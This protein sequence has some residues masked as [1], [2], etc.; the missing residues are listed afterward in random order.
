M[1]IYKSVHH[2]VHTHTYIYIYLYTDSKYTA[3]EWEEHDWM[4]TL[5]TLVLQVFEASIPMVGICF[6]HQFLAC[7]LGG[8]SGVSN[9]GWDC[10]YTQME[11]IKD[12]WAAFLADVGC[13]DLQTA[14]DFFLPEY[15]RDAVLTL[16]TGAD[17]L[18]SSQLCENEMY[19]IGKKVMCIQGHPELTHALIAEYVRRDA[20]DA[21]S[22]IPK[23]I[24]D[25]AAR[26]L[27]LKEAD[28]ATVQPPFRRMVRG[29]LGL[30]PLTAPSETKSN[31]PTAKKSGCSIL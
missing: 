8:A 12:N 19:R 9:R 29:F 22:P 4:K 21:N 18:L 28:D 31:P 6:G 17:L 30:P 16:P 27:E 15:H 11:P 10:G 25:R 5:R 20:L 7:V 14:T 3:H 24:Q 1:C 2:C 13:E 26:T 23:E